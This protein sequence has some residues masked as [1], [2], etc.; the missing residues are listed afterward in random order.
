MVK[1]LIIGSCEPFSGKSA[2]DLGIARHLKVSGKSIRFGKPL[3][4]SIELDDNTSHGTNSLLDDDVLFAGS[5]LDLSKD[6]LIPSVHFLTSDTADKRLKHGQLDPGE[7]FE[8][9]KEKLDSY[10]DGLNI[11][12]TAGWLH[13][14]LL[15]GLSLEQVSQG[16]DAKVLLVH[17]WRDSTSVDLSLIHI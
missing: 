17:L 10:S 16:L 7:G 6:Q 8:K 12:E 4:T 9:L 13:E 2:L 5:I 3:A 1:T 14:G 11:L 15:Y